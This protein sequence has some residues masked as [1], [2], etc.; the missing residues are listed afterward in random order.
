MRKIVFLIVILAYTM[1]GNSQNILFYDDFESGMG[2][3]TYTGTWG[4]SSAA[5]TGLWA[6]SE[7]PNGNYPDLTTMTATMDTSI[8]LSNALDAEAL[9]AATFS[10]E[11]GFDFMYFQASS[12]GGQTWVTIDAF[13]GDSA[14]WKYTYSLGG[15]VGSS[16]VRCRFKFVSDPALNFDGMNI[17]DFM[18]MSYTVDNTPPL[19]VHN[20]LPHYEGSLYE[21]QVL[22]EIVDVSGVNYATLSYRVDNVLQS[23]V[24]GI[25]YSGNNWLFEIPNVSPGAWVE[26]QITAQDLSTN[27]NS[28]ISDTFRFVA[29]NY[30]KYD[31]AFVSF[32]GTVSPFSTFETGA[33][34]KISLNGTTNLVTALIRNYVDLNNPNAD[35]EVHVWA[36]D[37]A[38]NPGADMI[39][40]FY[41]TPAANA[42]EPHKMTRI[43]LRPYSDSLVGIWGD[44]FVG[45]KAPLGDVHV[46]QTT[47]GVGGH[48]YIQAFGVWNLDGDD[49]HFRAI[50]SAISGAPISNFSYDTINDPSV[51]FTDLSLNTPIAWH[52]D[53]GDAG[54]ISTDQNPNHAFTQN[55]TYNVCL[56]VDNGI[57]TNTSCQFVSV[58]NVQAPVA[59]FSYLTTYSPEILFVD[60]S[61]NFPLSWHWDFDDNG[62]TW[63]YLNPMHTF[64]HNDTFHVCL[65]VQ[66][67]AGGDTLC[68]DI[69]INDYTAPEAAYSYNM[70][71]SP[72]IQF[73]D[74]SS[75]QIINTPENWYWDFDDNGATSIDTNALHLFSANG[76]YTICLTVNNQY[77]SDQYC[78]QVVIN[79]Y[80]APIANFSYSVV[81]GPKL[82]F[83]DQS[84]DSLIN[85]ATSWHWDFGDGTPVNTLQSP[86]HTFPQNGTFTVCL[87]ASNSM[88]SDTICQIVEISAYDFPTAYFS[89]NNVTQPVVFFTDQSL[90]YPQTYLWDFDDQGNTSAEKNPAYTFSTNDTFNVCLTVSNYLGSDTICWPVTI[91]SYLPPVASFSYQ[92]EDDTIVHFHDL[93]THMPTIWLWDFDF[94]GQTSI[95]QHPT[96][97][98]TIPGDY[99][100]CLTTSNS[101]GTSAAFCQLVS[102]VINESE[103]VSGKQLIKIYPQPMQDIIN[104][105]IPYQD[106]NQYELFIYNLLGERIAPKTSRQEN[107]IVLYRNSL[108]A[109]IYL[110]D[111]Q[112]K[113]GSVFKGK[114]LME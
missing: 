33:A 73:Y 8:D 57:T 47:P 4:L 30:I 48:T 100:V 11:Y 76:V 6:M 109:G 63:N 15:F 111:I 42:A 34:V 9:F 53:F 60:S 22:A 112:D 62:A 52:W 83:T 35:M 101:V 7:S 87:I 39:V 85:A 38:G 26:Y 55:G 93:S 66:N 51:S 84:T 80:V 27:F 13:H 71:L 59:V 29:G 98:Y 90:G 3:W 10:I 21:H 99:N 102:I 43:D 20:P 96:M 40:P 88:G 81:S 108:P 103:L 28:A 44:I 5:F 91:T 94:N 36:A 65:T 1:A 19:I 104:I 17:D 50:T 92:I 107:K 37:S 32:V 113:T 25:N 114:I 46:G 78:N 72:W 77:G 70:S 110:I 74:E 18:I 23:T 67:N 64:S 41:V 86:L 2:N 12:N 14:W 68:Q 49:Y 89:Y 105:E 45:I 79:S 56:T 61:L 95:G 97:V 16:D 31:N 24:S 69:I 75:G 54:T 58:Q 82:Q 106:E